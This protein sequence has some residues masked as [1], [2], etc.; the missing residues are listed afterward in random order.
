MRYVGPLFWI[1]SVLTP[2]GRRLIEQKTL[3]GMGFGNKKISNNKC[4]PRSNYVYYSCLSDLDRRGVLFKSIRD[5]SS[6]DPT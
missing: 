2:R 1:K 3:E 6:F 5:H 4:T